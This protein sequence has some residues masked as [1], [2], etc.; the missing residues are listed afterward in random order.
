MDTAVTVL[1]YED[2]KTGGTRP[3]EAALAA[4]LVGDKPEELGGQFYG[5]GKRREPKNPANIRVR[6]AMIA[7]PEEYQVKDIEKFKAT[8]GSGYGVFVQKVVGESEKLKGDGFDSLKIVS[9]M[10]K[11]LPKKQKDEFN[12]IA[13][14][15]PTKSSRRKDDLP[16]GWRVETENFKRRYVCDEMNVYTTSRPKKLVKR[17]LHNKKKKVHATLSFFMTQNPTLNL[18]EAFDK[19]NSLSAEEKEE[20]ETKK[21][22]FFNTRDETN[23]DLEKR[24]TGERFEPTASAAAAALA[25]ASH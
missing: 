2:E 6:P 3:V 24:L 10:W 23:A 7:L 5:F 20:W 19:W 15:A 12:E 4:K 18:K 1:S 17:N 21:I 14:K 13:G 11:K 9:A 8:P 25:A 16:P 22:A